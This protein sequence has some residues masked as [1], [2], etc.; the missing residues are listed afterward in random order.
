M[1]ADW[2]YM[3]NN[4]KYGPFDL[5]LLRQL[6]DAGSLAETDLVW[7]EGSPAWVPIAASAPGG[8]TPANEPSL[9]STPVDSTQESKAKRDAGH[10]RPEIGKAIGGLVVVGLLLIGFVGWL[11]TTPDQPSYEKAMK[12]REPVGAAARPYYVVR[13][14]VQVPGQAEAQWHYLA[15]DHR[16]T[17]PQDDILK[18]TARFDMEYKA[19]QA[20]EE[21]KAFQRAAGQADGTPFIEKRTPSQR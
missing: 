12:A 14:L 1:S 7:Q 11:F 18:H 4:Q 8:D 10:Y 2:Y 9:V 6:V 5:S 16:S 15:R 19:K 13:V 17:T 3:K 21:W 20:A